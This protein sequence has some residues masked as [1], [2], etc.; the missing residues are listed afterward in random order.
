LEVNAEFCIGIGLKDDQRD[1]TNRLANRHGTEEEHE[2]DIDEQEKLH[3]VRI[4]ALFL[5]EEK[6][7][8]PR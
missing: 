2:C 1:F 8:I 6:K 5:L 4:D 3:A 7:A